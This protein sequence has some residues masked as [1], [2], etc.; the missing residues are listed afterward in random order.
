MTH[1]LVTGATGFVGHHLVKRLTNRGVDVSCLVRENSQRSALEELGASF[2]VGDVTDP[3]SLPGALADVDV[4]YHVAGVTKCLDMREMSRVNEEGVRNIAK[5]CGALARPPVLV[6]VSSLAAAGPSSGAAPKRESDTAEPL[7]IYGRSKRAGELAANEF[8]DRVPTTI[9]RPPIVLGEED[10]SGFQLFSMLRKFRFHLVPGFQP[11]SFSVI[12]GDDLAQAL[13]VAAE[14]GKRLTTDPSDPTG[15]YFAT[16]DEIVTYAELG[17]MIGIAVGR[18]RAWMIRVP[19]FVVW[20]AGGA[21]ELMAKITRKPNIM[22]IDKAREAS[23]G[24]WVC[25]SEQLKQDTGFQPEKTL[26][27]RLEQTVAGYQAKG[28]LKL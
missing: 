19:M 5:A 2:V 16:N 8:A 26:R 11:H 12:H 6:V 3:E 24:S 22:N 4:I 21:N 23:A 17:R 25:T 14:K 18:P 10:S 27:E 15:I 7:S 28:W 9:V 13:M 1:A 20:F